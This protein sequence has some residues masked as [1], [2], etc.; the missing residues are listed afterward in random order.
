MSNIIEISKSSTPKLSV[1]GL[2]D[3]GALK[4]KS[5]ST[6]APGKSPGAS[7]KSVNFGPGIEM[8]MNPKKNPTSPMKS[9]INISD[10]EALN[11]KLDVQVSGMSRK[12]ANKK[13]FFTDYASQAD[14]LI[15]FVEYKSQAKWKNKEKM[16][17]FY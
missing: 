1:I 10:L 17:I 4:L 2:G 14:V 15:Y 6:K 16:Y 13:I 9:D 5:P 3:K 8:L 12:Q 11:K 7:Q